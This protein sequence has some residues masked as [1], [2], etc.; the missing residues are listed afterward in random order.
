MIYFLN[1]ITTDTNDIS[2]MLTHSVEPSQK[3]GSVES[4]Q[5]TR[6]KVTKILFVVKVPVISQALELANQPEIFQVEVLRIRSLPYMSLV[7]LR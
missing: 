4:L 6:E 7:F 5:F 1:I 3:F 2:K